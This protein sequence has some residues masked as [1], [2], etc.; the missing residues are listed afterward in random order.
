MEKGRILTNSASS[1]LPTERKPMGFS[2]KAI[3]AGIEADPTTGSLMTPIHLTST[4]LQEELGKDKG[5]V[6]SR[7][8]NPT[9]TVL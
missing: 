9:R 1:T 2:T 6:Y 4:F 3:H 7:V 8:A 5:Y